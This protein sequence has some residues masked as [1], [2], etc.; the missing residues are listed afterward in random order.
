MIARVTK[1]FAGSWLLALVVGI[2]IALVVVVALV[3][4][5]GGG[6]TD[7]ERLA[8]GECFDVPQAAD[9]IGDVRRRPC[10]GPH[11]GEV[12][13]VFDTTDPASPGY[14]SD[15]DWEAL[16]YPVCDPAFETFTGTLVPE[17]LDIEY[18]YFVPTADRWAAGNRHVTCYIV[19]ADGSPLTRSSRAAP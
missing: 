6:T 9:R 4:T 10:S 16:V 18:R 11:G 13:H 19:S 14:P 17:R 3:V 5:R 7:P 8:I 1:R 2:G 12:F 15:T